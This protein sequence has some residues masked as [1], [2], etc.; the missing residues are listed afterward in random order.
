MTMAMGDQL[1]LHA[2][3]SGG[4]QVT[5]TLINMAT[6]T[7]ISHVWRMGAGATITPTKLCREL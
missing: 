2:E 1:P 4:R 5:M 6:S 3:G 7:I